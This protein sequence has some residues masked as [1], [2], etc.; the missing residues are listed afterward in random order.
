MRS[1]LTLFALGA[2]LVLA[3]C[4]RKYQPG[5]PAPQAGHNLG[6]IACREY[7]YSNP[8]LCQSEALA[9]FKGSYPGTTAEAL[10]KVSTNPLV[11]SMKAKGEEVEIRFA[12][13]SDEDLLKYG[14]F[15][16]YYEVK[17]IHGRT[18]QEEINEAAREFSVLPGDILQS[19][20][21]DE[22]GVEKKRPWRAILKRKKP[23]QLRMATD[24][25]DETY[26]IVTNPPYPR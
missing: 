4:A 1:N 15:I 3:A 25:D 13:V 26:G 2:I 20:F 12:V 9:F 16:N 22:V 6:R 11:Y 18:D 5:A 14:G 19:A 24:G 23:A 8:V 21:Q 10:T 7:R 17:K